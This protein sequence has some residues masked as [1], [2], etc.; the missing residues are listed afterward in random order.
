[1]GS[2]DST[3][4]LLDEEELCAVAGPVSLRGTGIL[5]GGS[6]IRRFFEDMLCSELHRI[7]DHELFEAFGAGDLVRAIHY[8]KAGQ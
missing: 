1:M 6:C 4:K 7:S 2:T 3:F 5:P 8:G